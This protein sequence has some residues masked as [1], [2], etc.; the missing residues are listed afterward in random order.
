MA[1]N[2]EGGL[3]ID[4]DWKAEAAREKELLTEQEHPAEASGGPI[5]AEANFIE[6]VNLLAMQTAVSLGGMQQPG[7]PSIPPNPIAAKHFIDLLEVLHTKT[8]GN[9][10][11]D[12]KKILESVLHELRMQYVQTVSHQSPPPGIG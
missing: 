11:G 1:E 12:E 3:H 7:E 6:L 2:S 8:E 5:N 10:T 4:S 9:L